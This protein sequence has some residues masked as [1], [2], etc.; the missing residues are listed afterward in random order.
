MFFSLEDVARLADRVAM[1]EMLKSIRLTA[2]LQHVYTV[3]ESKSSI[4]IGD[5]SALTPDFLME[6]RITH[7]ICILQSS[8]IEDKPPALNW[9][10]KEDRHRD[11]AKGEVPNVEVITLVLDV[12]DSDRGEEAWGLFSVNIKML[13][14]C[15]LSST[16]VILVCFCYFLICF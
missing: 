12:E 4:W 5:H 6:L 1:Y 10:G 8:E 9:L 2:P 7:L 13:S 14:D 3:E 11:K 16:M 15:V